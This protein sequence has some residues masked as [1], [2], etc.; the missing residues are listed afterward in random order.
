V[1]SLAFEPPV[2]PEDLH[3][4]YATLIGYAEG[5][6][7][8]GTLRTP[9]RAAK[10]WANM[11][12][13]YRIDPASL[14]TTFDS[15]GHDELVIVRSIPFYSLCEHHLLPFHGEAHV[16]YIP[17]GRIVGLSK[18]ARVVDAY[19]RRLQVQER[20]TEQVAELLDDGLAAR[21]VI[22]VVEA[23]HLCMSMRGVHERRSR[24]LEG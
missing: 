24:P 18:I 11:M 14:L 22:V 9:E 16:G 8:E 6:I 17:N 10:A 7:R 5:E 23:E 20:L 13:G 3:T 12:I 15:E 4:A 19:A 21:G 1:S 2:H